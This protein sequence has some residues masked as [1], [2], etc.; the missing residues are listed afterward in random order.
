[1]Q[2]LRDA[3]WVEITGRRGYRAVRRTDLGRR[4]FNAEH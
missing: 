1:M 2:R 3:G 4:V